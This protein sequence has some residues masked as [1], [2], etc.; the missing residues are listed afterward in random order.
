MSVIVVGGGAAG[1]MAAAAAAQLGAK[2][3]LLE[4]NE[5]LGKKLYITGKGRC[6]VT[7][8]CET[9]EIFGRILRNA[10]FMYSAIYTFD[11]FRVMDFFEQ[12]QTPLKTERGGRVFPVSGHA[13]DIIRA[14]AQAMQ[15]SNVDVRLHTRVA[16]VAKENGCFL[17]TDTDGKAYAADKVIVATGGVS[18]PAT[19][20]TGDG[21]V[22]AKHFG[23]T[24]EKLKPSLTAMY[25]REDYIPR[26]Q[27]LALKNVRARI[28]DRS[29][30]LYDDFGELLFTH[31]G[32]SG[33]LML[34]ASAVINDRLSDAPLQL[35][36]DLKP[37][38]SPEQLDQRLLRDFEKLHN[39][40]FKN[41]LGGL[42]PSTMIPV[43][44][45]LCG[46]DP[47]QKV[48][49]I[50]KEERRRLLH[51]LKHFPATLTG[52][53]D[54]TEAIIT[55]GGVNVKEVDPST[56]ESRL[57]KGLYFAGETLD[58]DALT[59][60]YNLQIAWS[61]GYLAGVSAGGPCSEANN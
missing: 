55:R 61:S 49:D 44:I 33:P 60:G 26:L 29:K 16:S 3:L 9:Q 34:S 39:K 7:N 38:L 48:H 56:M 32:V 22:I 57:E 53:R 43:V 23:H 37:A 5:K 28:Y 45:E 20:S 17:V 18:Y 47:E 2:V 50:T 1:M 41:A 31:F 52:F 54:F 24:V 51:V 25:T 21:Y 13:S 4:R 58:V 14:L 59:G 36:V 8:A 10:K 42:L 6:N 30:V 40:Q 35:A 46:I 11:N 12:H 15:H 19:G 27:G